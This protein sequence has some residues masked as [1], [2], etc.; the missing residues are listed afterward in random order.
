MG[1]DM[2]SESYQALVDRLRVAELRPTRQRLA[3]GF[4]LFS[5]EHRHVTAEM[6]HMETHDT[7]EHVS[8]ATVYNTLHQFTEA[9]LLREI[10]VSGTKTYFDTNLSE[11]HHFYRED[12]DE[13][14]DIPDGQMRIT[15]L[16]PVPEGMAIERVDVIVRLRKFDA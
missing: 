8:L 16:P 15:G 6:L 10:H 2:A 7:G 9:G 14:V 11:H 13:L 5:G 3:L 1:M 12:I 4:L